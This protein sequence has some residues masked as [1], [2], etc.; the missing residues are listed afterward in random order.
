MPDFDPEDI[1]RRAALAAR[2]DVLFTSE[3]AVAYDRDVVREFDTV[4]SEEQAHDVQHLVMPD[5]PSSESDP[6]VRA[7]DKNGRAG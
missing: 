1:Q 4:S 2:K 6:T 5:V 3:E 7:F